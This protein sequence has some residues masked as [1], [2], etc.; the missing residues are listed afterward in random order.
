MNS[1][2]KNVYKGVPFY[3]KVVND[4]YYDIF[5][6]KVINESATEQ[7][8]LT[9]Y[10]GLTI[11]YNN[12]AIVIGTGNL[13]NYE[14][15]P[16]TRRCWGDPLKRYV[17]NSDSNG[18]ILQ[19]ILFDGDDGTAATW[20]AFY[21]YQTKDIKFSKQA[22]LSGFAW[23][24]SLVLGAHDVNSWANANFSEKGSV[25]YEYPLV[26][27]FSEN[28]YLESSTSLP[29]GQYFASTLRFISRVTTGDSVS[30]PKN[31]YWDST[32]HNHGYGVY[33]S[34]WRIYNGSNNTGG[35]AL[36]NTTYW[37]MLIQS[38]QGNTKLYYMLD[39][40]T[41][42]RDTLP[43]VDDWELTVTV[44][45]MLFDNTGQKV[46]IGNASV[47]KSEYWNGKI[48]LT[49]LKIDT[50]TSGANGTVTWS[51]LWKAIG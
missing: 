13:P 23:V 17:I 24:G 15:Y 22:K 31:I 43:D 7:I 8:A 44:N 9:P 4:R 32:N 14:E 11:S 27:G 40:G 19:G 10:A 26:S 30:S 21:S 29:N 18:E 45:G 3:V 5:A 50:V 34:K 16:G 33:N 41:Y 48:D 6:T 2:T 51:N 39:D 47:T 20:N 42:E 36:A 38:T 49:S 37:V 1:V 25:S 35:T 46:I 28:S 12:G